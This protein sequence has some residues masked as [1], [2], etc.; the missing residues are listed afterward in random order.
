MSRRVD[1]NFDG[2][3]RH[4]TETPSPVKSQKG[5]PSINTNVVDAAYVAD[6]PSSHVRG[7][8]HK[9]EIGVNSHHDYDHH[10]GNRSSAPASH[11]TT[12]TT[13]TD[14]SA[15][16]SKSSS[17]GSYAIGLIILFI[18]IIIIVAAAIYMGKPGC[19]TKDGSRGGDGE[20]DILK[21]GLTV[22]IVAIIIILIFAGIYWLCTK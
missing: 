20:L 16:C 4:Q 5:G 2:Y 7:A 13:T 12:T 10:H 18:I 21:A 6:T 15:D 8:M 17:N 14:S 9:E 3:G 11:T 22:F 1:S 19:L